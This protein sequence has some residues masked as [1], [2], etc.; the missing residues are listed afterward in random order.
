MLL[1]ELLAGG[2]ANCV[3]SA[4]F[5]FTDVVKVRMQVQPARAEMHYRSFTHACRTILA[6]EGL[7]GLLLPGLTASMLRD[8]SYSS[9]RFGL[10]GPV[11]GAFMKLLHVEP[12][13]AQN[14][15]SRMK[16]SEPLLLK[17][18]AGVTSGCIG[19]SLANPTDLVKIRMQAEAGRLGPDGV[20][21]S[22]LQKGHRPKYPNTFVAFYTIAKNEGIAS[23]YRGVQ[24]TAIRASLL[25]SGQLA[26]Y[27]ETKYLMKKYGIMQE[28]LN[29]HVVASIVAGLVACTVCAPADIIKTRLLGQSRG[30]GL[31]PT[32]P[33]YRGFVHCFTSIVRTEGV[34]TLFRGW[35]PS[36]M[37]LAPHFIIS[38]PL[39]EQLR[40]TF[41]LDAI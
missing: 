39:F 35:L 17:I 12:A 16:G 15:Q 30:A 26:S 29:L 10:Y 40:R 21:V 1:L 41:G 34:L 24:A 19:S 37:R 20:F 31:D 27:D 8:I 36:Y 33:H 13:S 2:I 28:G 4:T 9:M 3:P 5:N 14:P 11:K 25:T 7:R 38:L 23:L 22:G 6:E 32:H 18:A